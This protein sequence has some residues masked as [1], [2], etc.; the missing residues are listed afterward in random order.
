M[1][2]ISVT[3]TPPSLNVIQDDA[4]RSAASLSA[5]AW[6]YCDLISERCAVVWSHKKRISW[7][8]PSGEFGF[9]LKRGKEIEKGTQAYECFSGTR[10]HSKP[11]PVRA[12]L[13]LD[14]RVIKE[15]SLIWGHSIG[16][17]FY[18]SILSL[19]RIK[20]R[21]DRYSEYDEPATEE[22]DPYHFDAVRVRRRRVQASWFHLA[23]SA[24]ETAVAKP[25]RD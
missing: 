18:D 20:E 13:W 9:F 14:E 22:L 7:Y 2:R 21:I 17:P 12:D 5:T 15:D 16:L 1:S 25:V 3:D 24:G 6:R 19:L 4:E 11:E 8:K 10:I 23:A